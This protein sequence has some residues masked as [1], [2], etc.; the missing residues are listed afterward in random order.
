MWLSQSCGAR[1]DREIEAH[2]WRRS[3]ALKIFP[4]DS[5]KGQLHPIVGQ[6]GTCAMLMCGNDDDFSVLSFHGDKLQSIVFLVMK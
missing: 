3:E 2:A 5:A 6:R 4:L 1:S